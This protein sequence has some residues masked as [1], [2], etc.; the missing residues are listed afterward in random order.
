M[1]S[2]ATS[3]TRPARMHSPVSAVVTS[4]EIAVH[5]SSR[6]FVR[7][8]STMTGMNTDASTP[9]SSSS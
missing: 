3:A 1:I 4:A 2:G 6:S 8:S 7:S 5:A 9:P